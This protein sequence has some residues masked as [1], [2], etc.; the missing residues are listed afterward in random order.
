MARWRSRT[1][2]VIAQRR[3]RIQNANVILVMDKGRIVERGD[4]D[5]FMVS[6]ALL[7]LFNGQFAGIVT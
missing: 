5:A 6:R 3:S 4:H 1:S 2:F 7:R